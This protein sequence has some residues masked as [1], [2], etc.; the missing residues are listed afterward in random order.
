MT[1]LIFKDWKSEKCKEKTIIMPIVSISHGKSPGY[2][3]NLIDHRFVKPISVISETAKLIIVTPMQYA[4]PFDEW[5]N[6]LPEIRK[7]DT[8]RGN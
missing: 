7:I 1:P 2:M 3:K 6:P 8:Q 5:E 4:P